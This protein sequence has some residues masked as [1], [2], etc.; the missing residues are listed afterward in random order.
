MSPTVHNVALSPLQR[1]R[2]QHHVTQAQL[3]TD[4][5]VHPSVVSQWENGHSVPSLRK[6][7]ELH[8]HTG[9]AVHALLRFFVPLPPVLAARGVVVQFSLTR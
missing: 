4:M 3:A 2:R 1:W 8:R 5:G 9:I 7:H 6:F